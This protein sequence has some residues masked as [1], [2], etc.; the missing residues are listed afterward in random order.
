MIYGECLALTSA[1]LWGTIPVLVR[2]DCTPAPQLAVVVG[3]IASCPLLFG[4]FLLHPRPVWYAVTLSRLV[5]CRGWRMDPA[6]SFVQLYGVERLGAARA[7]PLINSSLFTTLLA[8][9]FT[10]THHLPDSPR[11]SV[12]SAVLPF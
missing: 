12:S 2:K 8:L 1:L 10:R 9:I 6:W 11:R 5:V 7:T 4:V 3:L